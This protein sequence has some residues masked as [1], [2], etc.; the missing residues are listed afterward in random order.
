MAIDNYAALIS[1]VATTVNRPDQFANITDWIYL[2]EQDLN[3]V[4][5]RREMTQLATASTTADQASYAL[6]VDFDEAI[7]LHLNGSPLTV[8]DPSDWDGQILLHQDFTG[9]PQRYSITQN[10]FL[11]APTPDAA[12]TIELYYY[13][14]LANLTGANTTN[15]LLT[16]YPQLYL[17]GTLAMAAMTL[18]DDKRS[19]KWVQAYQATI[20]RVIADQ[21]RARGFGGGPLLRADLPFGRGSSNNILNDA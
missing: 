6:P 1:A 13:K 12:Y 21:V 19:G 8:L 3:I 5:H 9:R 14:T 10:Q 15:W 20:K 7:S 11:L 2:C 17:F 16:A 18:D 4:L